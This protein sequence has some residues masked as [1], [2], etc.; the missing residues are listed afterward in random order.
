[1]PSRSS[2][3]ENNPLGEF[4]VGKMYQKAFLKL[5]RLAEGKT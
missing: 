1:M 3:T 2:Q 5:L 4:G